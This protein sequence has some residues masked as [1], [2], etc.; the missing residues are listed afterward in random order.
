MNT[1]DQLTHIENVQKDITSVCFNECFGKKFKIDD[2]CVETCYQKY[3]TTLN[4]VHK[5]LI[6]DG[7]QL[8]SEFVVTSVGEKPPDRFTDELFEKGGFN[9]A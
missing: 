3:I 8:K 5:K 4:H 9:M 6:R 2:A 7:R 1:R